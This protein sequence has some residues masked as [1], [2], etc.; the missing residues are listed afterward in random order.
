MF[1]TRCRYELRILGKWVL[2]IPVG[3]MIGVAILLLIYRVI[4]PQV[5]SSQTE[6]ILTGS[7]EMVLPLATALVIGT[8][9]TRDQ[10]GEV[11]LALPA[12]YARTAF[13]RVGLIVGW[14]IV[15]ALVACAV[16]YPLGL[17]HR[18]QQLQSWSIAGQWL[19][20]QLVW[21]APLF[22][23]A[24]LAF[25]L[26]L[27]LRSRA[28][29]GGLVGAIW[30]LESFFY[31]MF[32]STTW[33]Q[34]VYLF[35]TTFTPNVSFWLTNRLELLA[36]ALVLFILSWLLLRRSEALVQGVGGEEV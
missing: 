18:P 21:A 9:G 30:T 19:T 31:L 20:G 5:G 34:P 11:Q 14:S 26:A 27:L 13:L 7:L 23:L 24:A 2:L 10:M 4:I 35:P 28:A 6:K 29:S 36:L 16:I 22:S 1:L 8:I 17:W 25:C 33:L 15:I 32:S 3:T 12:S